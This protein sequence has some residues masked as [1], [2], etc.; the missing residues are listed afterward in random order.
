ME[1]VY[2]STPA[3]SL[4][5][6]VGSLSRG[7]RAGKGHST[8]SEYRPIYCGGKG[9]KPSTST[10]FRQVDMAQEL[11]ELDLAT[12]V[13]GAEFGEITLSDESVI[14]IGQAKKTTRDFAPGVEYPVDYS[15]AWQWARLV[16]FMANATRLD[17]K[18]LGSNCCFLVGMIAGA[19]PD[20]VSNVVDFAHRYLKGL[21]EKKL[22]VASE[23]YRR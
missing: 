9:P 17:P 23:N 18:N 14:Y 4:Q 12:R 16:S 20:N 21:T 5:G 2:G 3:R 11:A 6:L 1:R 10:K 7:V 13:F 15:V 19:Y 8:L 22:G